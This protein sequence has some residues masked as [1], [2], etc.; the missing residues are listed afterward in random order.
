M[1]RSSPRVKIQS[2]YSVDGYCCDSPLLTEV[3]HGWRVLV[4]GPAVGDD[5]AAFAKEPVWCASGRRP[6][7]DQRHHPCAEGGVPLA[8]LSS[9]L[10]PA[11][12]RLLQRLQHGHGAVAQE[13][14]MLALGLRPLLG[15]GPGLRI[16]VASHWAAC[17]AFFQPAW[18]ALMYAAAACLKVMARASSSRLACRSA[19]RASIG[20]TPSA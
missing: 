15:D 17:L 14:P 19:L 7:R 3:D 13:D 20:S 1:A 10:W 16:Q 2:S 12:D 5:R 11:D 4:V 6:T 8:G 9:A 18:L